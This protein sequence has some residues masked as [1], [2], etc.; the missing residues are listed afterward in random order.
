M[1]PPEDLRPVSLPSGVV[2]LRIHGVSGTPP[3]SLLKATPIRVAGSPKSGFYRSRASDSPEGLIEAYSWGG[4]TSGSRAS[5]LWLLLLPFA[6]VNVGGWMLPTIRE[7]RNDTFWTKVLVLAGRLVA[8]GLTLMLSAALFI[9]ASTALE[10]S[11]PWSEG[12]L[13]A[14][15]DAWSSIGTEPRVSLAATAVLASVVLGLFQMIAL[16]GSRRETSTHLR[17][18]LELASD[19][20]PFAGLWGGASFVRFL[21]LTHLGAAWGCVAVVTAIAVDGR[22][23]GWSGLATFGG[24]LAIFLGLLTLVFI[25]FES[26]VVADWLETITWAIGALAVLGAA[27]VS[28]HSDA[29]A[30]VQ[31]ETADSVSLT[32]AVA[33][34]GFTTVIIFIVVVM[35]VML[36][37]HLFIGDQGRF[38]SIAFITWGFAAAASA[39]A[40]LLIVLGPK[41]R[42]SVDLAAWVFAA[43]GLLAIAWFLWLWNPLKGP[44]VGRA[45]RIRE[46][47]ERGVTIVRCTGLGLAVTV[48]GGLAWFVASSSERWFID[49]RLPD[50][51]STWGGA[52]GLV[53]TLAVLGALVRPVWKSAAV[54]L[55]AVT[56]LVWLISGPLGEIYG[57]EIVLALD[58]EAVGQKFVDYAGYVGMVAPIFAT[59]WFVFRASGRRSNRR[60]VG[61][62]WDLANYWPRWSHPWAPA[63]YNEVAIAA[64]QDRL[65]FLVGKG[66]TVVVSGHSQGAVMAVPILHGLDSALDLRFLSYGCLIDRHY[67]MLFPRFFN[68]TVF[69][70]VDDN[71]GGRW[72]NLHRIT[73]PLGHRVR[74]LQTRSVEASHREPELGERLLTHSDYQYSEQYQS[75]LDVLLEDLTGGSGDS[76]AAES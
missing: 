1:E 27:L 73:D 75:S 23:Q 48:S 68:D 6:L 11:L 2:E 28:L 56:G 30:G 45:K 20:A 7:G 59:I 15:A 29:G 32:E 37:I 43:A 16:I 38:N 10:Q 25:S 34:G 13:G 33:A 40:G 55:V 24:F 51:N 4:L 53:L 18:T 8:L 49:G 64:L 61:V 69:G 54:A 67:R 76:G 70:S 50:P 52:V 3:E 71:V 74:A 41:P 63:P 35:V 21:G 39:P 58:L 62:F 42:P 17:E 57:S 14:L 36:L 12:P 9:V 47:V 60:A 65:E 44:A 22:G 5:A 26:T 31:P 66:K 19:P 72:I 46:A